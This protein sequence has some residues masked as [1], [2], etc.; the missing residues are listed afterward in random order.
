ML[1][2]RELIWPGA[3][4]GRVGK[5][6]PIFSVLRKL[7]NDTLRS[8]LSRWTSRD[9]QGDG[10]GRWKMTQTD[11]HSPSL[12]AVLSQD[13]AAQLGSLRA[14]K[15]DVIGHPLRKTVY[16]EQ[17]LLPALLQL[18]RNGTTPA[19]VRIEA[20]VVLGSLLHGSGEI[21][22]AI[23]TDRLSAR[24]RKPRGHHTDS[25]RDSRAECLHSSANN[26]LAPFPRQLVRILSLG[27]DLSS[28]SFHLPALGSDL[29]SPPQAI[30]ES[31]HNRARST[32]CYALGTVL[33]VHRQS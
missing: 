33:G 12:K 17:S 3:P 29:S 7:H 15:D 21:S 10:K 14:F 11:Q 28:I 2:S 1:A 31:C 18:L 16:I 5:L 4:P 8:A 19:E 27:C 24:R 26:C 22:L 6:S 30:T 32:S 13:P 25:H 23:L 9:R 20:T